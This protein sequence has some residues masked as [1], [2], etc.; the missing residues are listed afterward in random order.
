[1][2]IHFQFHFEDEVDDGA[3]RHAPVGITY[4]GHVDGKILQGIGGVL[5]TA[6]K[7][8]KVEEKL[9]PDIA[10]VGVLQILSHVIV[11]VMGVVVKEIVACEPH[12]DTIGLSLAVSLFG[13]G[14]GIPGNSSTPNMA[15]G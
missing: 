7:D 8:G 15:L 4:D 10:I 12:T 3:G 9:E 13:S 1:M 11:K 5:L 14:F 2:V 6:T